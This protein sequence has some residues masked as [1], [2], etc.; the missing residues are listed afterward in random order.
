[1]IYIF[2][3]Q[4]GLEICVLKPVPTSDEL[5]RVKILHA[6][7]IMDTD[8]EERF[9]RLTRMAKRIFQVPIALVSLVDENRQWFKS[10]DGL[11]VAETPRDIS[12]CGHAILGDEIFVIPDATIDARFFDNPLVTGEPYVRFYA[13]C[14]LRAA[15]GAKVGT[16]C[17]IDNNPRIFDADDATAMKDLAAMVEDELTAFQSATT[18]A[19]TRVSNRRGFSS[20]AP[21]S[22]NFC[23]RHMEPAT[24]VYL[25]LDCFKPVNDTY[26]HAEGDH[27]L[28]R[29][30]DGLRA[31]FRS[32]DVLARTGGDEF[33]VLMTGTGSQEAEFSLD[34][35]AVWLNEQ[36]TALDTP[37]RTQFSFGLVDYNP[38]TDP[39]VEALL[40]RGDAAMY[41]QKLR[42]RRLRV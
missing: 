27:A 8:P 10:C 25:D 26:G 9:D 13:G 21:Y 4:L 41:E 15:G 5:H 6:L 2:G 20:L 28:V 33:V 22:L 40:Q 42:R 37:Y 24:L 36:E 29:F 23:A 1:M 17:I 11:G 3:V 16:L 39:S 30:A 14:P 7:G 12:F 18:D 38:E 19:L 32:S 31:C 34:K 35:L